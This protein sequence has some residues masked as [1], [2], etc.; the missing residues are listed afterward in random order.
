MAPADGNNNLLISAPDQPPGTK[1]VSAAP[2]ASSLATDRS[3][4][5]GLGTPLMT[6]NMVT[7]LTVS[8]RKRFLYKD[9]DKV[10]KTINN[11]KS[12]WN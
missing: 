7:A 11:G 10:E 1:V 6:V 3:G 5:V 4:P 12:S 9:N 8:L 2:I